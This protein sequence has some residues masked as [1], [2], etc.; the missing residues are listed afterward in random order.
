M[1]EEF[2]HQIAIETLRLD[3]TASPAPW[4]SR[5]NGPYYSITCATDRLLI[6]RILGSTNREQNMLFVTQTRDNAPIL[7]QAVLDL[8]DEN[9]A[10][11]A[12]IKS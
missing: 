1:N 11:K 2:L 4:L 3:K 5:G 6:M 7:A 10:L 9:K 8:L 12:Q